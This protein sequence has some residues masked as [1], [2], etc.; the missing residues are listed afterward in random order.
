MNKKAVEKYALSLKGGEG[1]YPFGPEALVFKVMNKMYGLTSIHQDKPIVNLKCIPADGEVLID[2]Y[3]NIIPG[4]HMNKKHW[5]TI[6]L[7]DEVPDSV[8]KDLIE[9]SYNLVVSKLTKADKKKLE[10]L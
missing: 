4:Y 9:S 6:F 1:S 7:V 8:L 5:I 3:E 10:N 2:V